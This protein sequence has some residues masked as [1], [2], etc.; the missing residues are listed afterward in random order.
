MRRSRNVRCAS[1]TRRTTD[2]QDK[3]YSQVW[4]QRSNGWFGWFYPVCFRHLYWT[5]WFSKFVSRYD[6]L[7]LASDASLTTVL[8]RTWS[9]DSISN[10]I[11]DFLQRTHFSVYHILLFFYM[12]GLA[13]RDIGLWQCDRLCGKCITVAVTPILSHNFDADA[14][15]GPG[16]TSSGSRRNH[17]PKICQGCSGAQTFV[18]PNNHG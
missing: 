6:V 3:E 10:L 17:F 9:S 15:P 12:T 14:C 5:R 8:S 11:N 1:Q 2:V 13:C 4:I 16:C 18:R 7:T